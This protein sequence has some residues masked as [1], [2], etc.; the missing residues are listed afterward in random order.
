[1]ALS[2]VHPAAYAT[3]QEVP[4]RLS[5]GEWLERA[6]GTLLITRLA[7]V[8]ILL[9]VWEYIP[10][11]PGLRLHLRLQLRPFAGLEPVQHHLFAGDAAGLRGDGLHAPLR[12]LPA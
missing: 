6:P 7:I 11:R 3:T 5:L 1:M 8:A 2:T 4:E 12:R 9:L 10:A